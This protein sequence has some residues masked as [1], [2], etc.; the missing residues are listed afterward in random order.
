MVVDKCGMRRW[1]RPPG[2]PRQP[3]LMGAGGEHFIDPRSSLRQ[4]ITSNSTNHCLSPPTKKRTRTF[5]P[6][7]RP[8]KK[9]KPTLE[10]TKRKRASS[11]QAPKQQDRRKKQK[12]S[13]HINPWTIIS[14]RLR[15]LS[16]QATTTERR[17]TRIPTI[18]SNSSTKH[19]KPP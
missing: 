2:H 19:T 8:T 1:S 5:D 14:G 7:E 15:R 11:A 13:S 4:A 12:M 6:S 3:L 16:A 17:D 9:P 18:Q 10:S